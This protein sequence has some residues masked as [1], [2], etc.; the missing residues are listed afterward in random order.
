MTVTSTASEA[1]W[2]GPVPN[3]WS[4]RRLGT[5]GTFTKGTGGTKADNRD[6][7]I[8]VVRY[9]DLYT[10]F[11]T[12]ITAPAAYVDEDVASG[13]TPL[14]TGALV[15]T[16]SGEDPDD[17]GKA[18]LSL[19]PPPA[20][21]GGDSVL[22]HVN[23][24][25]DALF[26]VYAL[27]STPL[28]AHKAIRSTG[29]TVVHISAAKLKTL[30]VPTPP[31]AEQRAIAAYLDHETAQ[32]DALI[33]KQTMLVDGLRERREA[34]AAKV[35]SPLIGAGQRLKWS[36]REVDD[37]AGADSELPLLSVSIEW[38]VRLRDE[39]S[40]QQE[41]SEDL[42]RYKVARAGDVV[43][44]RMRAFQGGV[45]VAPG[46]GLVSPD[47]AVFRLNE[48]WDAAWAQLLFRSAPFV[49]EMAS[50]IRGIGTTDGANVRTP[51]I[52]P[53]DV[54]DI[55]VAAPGREEQSRQAAEVDADLRAV[56]LLVDRT[57][58]MLSL[59]RERRAALIT[60]AVTGQIDVTKK[61]AA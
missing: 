55:R 1:P 14:P 48:T 35:V 30:P 18:A 57:Q 3:S 40:I 25:A 58:K 29:F 13:Y 31:L 12:T 9:G 27:Q 44:N 24:E 60:A 46:A 37:R 15:F 52:S 56:D 61:E 17:I 19:L 32:I 22:M 47:Y 42:A 20:V 54:L 2:L 39:V 16:A 53:A 7:G 4:I 36:V 41:A 5:L 10:R 6:T 43:L 23:D 50:R 26:L 45:G 49:A 59:A 28:R 8:P 11:D 38:G 21:V 33:E 34:L 51:R